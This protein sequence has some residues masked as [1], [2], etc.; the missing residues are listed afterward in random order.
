[1]DTCLGG[2]SGGNMEKAGWK[3]GSVQSTGNRQFYETEGEK[4]QFIRES[5]Q[6]DTNAV[7][8]ADDKLNEAAIKLFLDNFVVLAKLPVNMA[9]PKC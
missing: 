9:K 4:H 3:A 5:F 7:L 8:K 1:M 6:L 2:A